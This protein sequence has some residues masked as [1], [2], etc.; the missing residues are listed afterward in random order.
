[1]KISALRGISMS[2]SLILTIFSIGFSG[3]VAQVLLLREL[4]IVFGGNELSIGIILSNWLVLGGLGSLI[5]AKWASKIK[6]GIE[7]LAIVAIILSL[8]LPL[9]IYLIRALKNIL[10]VAIGEGLGFSAMLSGSFL[11]LLP[12]SVSNGALFT[13]SCKVATGIF[14]SDAKSVIK[15]Y[16]YGTIGTIAGGIIWTY[17][18]L[19]HLDSFQISAAIAM[20]N[21]FAIILLLLYSPATGMLRKII[22]SASSLLFIVFAYL[23]FS[24]YATGLHLTSIQDQWKPLNLLHY[25]NSVYGNIVVTEVEGQYTFFLDGITYSM[26]PIPDIVATEEFV[27]TPLLTHPSPERILLLGK[28]GIINA[29]LK[30]PSVEVVDYS[31]LDPLLISL[32]RKFPVQL[33]RTEFDDERVRVNHIDGRQFLKISEDLYD[34]ILVGHSN[35]SD[36]R[37]NRYFTEG[38]FR[39]AQNRLSYNGILVM[40]LPGCLTYINE[41]LKNLHSSIFHTLKNVFPYVRAFPKQGRTLFFSS[42][43]SDILEMNNTLLLKR[44]SE[45]NLREDLTVPWHIERMLHPGW[46]QWFTQFIDGGSQR[47]NHD[48]MPR[49]VFYSLAHWNTRFAPY[50]RLPFQWMQ[51]LNLTILAALFII[52]IAYLLLFRVKKERALHMGIPMSVATTGFA[53]MIFDLMLI[54]TFQAA[55]GFVFSWI[56]LLIASFMTGIAAGAMII[57][58]TLEKVKNE[59]KLFMAFDLAIMLFSLILALIFV[60]F[61]SYLASP[62]AYPFLKGVFLLLSFISGFL[63]GGQFPLANKS[64]LNIKG[65]K[66]YTGT[67]ALIY[68]ADL[69]GGGAGGIIGGVILLPLLGLIGTCIILILLKLLSF[70]IIIDK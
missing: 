48:L 22:F 36:V 64:Y 8:S 46:T 41:E 49:A 59:K 13:L 18:L 19:P 57:L 43:Q 11:I 28:G 33:T 25:Q 52:V 21:I 51:R 10:G 39:L 6:S 42:N 26:V 5:M 53:G 65:Q 47:I 40:S 56:G 4:L 54:F 67:A 44:L 7:V 20:L 34:V 62:S 45:R 23:L 17:I 15:V 55:Y 60:A 58:S 9:S 61:S 30:H 16:I 12:I 69:L 24:G 38:F 31:E 70:V 3:L 35:P 68:G 29:I 14:G 50:L 37:S 1:M 63:V 66:E 32:K 2:K 27:H